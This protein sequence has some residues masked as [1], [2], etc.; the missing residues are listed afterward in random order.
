MQLHFIPTMAILLITSTCAF[1]PPAYPC[2]FIAS[3]ELPLRLPYTTSLLLANNND[4]S[5][6]NT[7][8]SDEER[9]LKAAA[10]TTT[11]GAKDLL[12][13]YGVAYLAT[14]IPLA[15]ASFGICY[16]LVSSGLPVAD[17]LSKFN[18]EV[19]SNSEVSNNILFCTENDEGESITLTN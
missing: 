9:E 5:T 3:R 18:I 19:N 12:S 1:V 14:S 6:T 4:D 17:V 10:A 16:A 8:D 13:K 7:S 15:A 11:M 2:C